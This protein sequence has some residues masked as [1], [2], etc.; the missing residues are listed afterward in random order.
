[1]KLNINSP[2]IEATKA[3]IRKRH[4]LADDAPVEV[5]TFTMEASTDGDPFA[6][7]AR[8]TTDTCDRD[9]EVVVPQGCDS[10]E[11]EKSGT[12]FWNHNYDMPV[13]K[14]NGKLVRGDRW[15]DSPAKFAF[16]P[17][18]YQGEFFPDFARA[19]VNQGIVK[20][21]SI[22]FMP[23]ESRKPT[24]KDFEA[25]GKNVE[26]VTNKWKLL[27][28]SIAPLQCNPDALIRDAVG[29]G[30]MSSDVAKSMFDVEPAADDKA[31]DSPAEEK[32][33][34]P[35]C[36]GELAED[37]TCAACAEKAKADDEDEDDKSGKSARRVVAA[38]A[39]PE[40]ARKARRIVTTL[41]EDAPSSRGSRTERIK[42]LVIADIRRQRGA[43]YDD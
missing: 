10:T 17:A 6:F 31:A 40:P 35:E 12:V 23:I 25:Y 43:I 14:A 4:G 11:F 37:G 19:M 42:K 20:G 15:I 9:F 30:I 13:A 7:K 22:G 16:R 3:L 18:D 24:P 2:N 29:K 38:V 34:C 28:W 8:I 39:M 26:R 41:V 33:L 32:K 1:M 27:E 36:E 21:V 5:K